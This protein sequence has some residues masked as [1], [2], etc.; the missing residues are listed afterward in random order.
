[1]AE[2]R[3][4]PKNKPISDADWV[5]V[6]EDGS[7]F[8]ASGS[9]DQGKVVFSP[10]P[11]RTEGAAISAALQHVIGLAPARAAL[12]TAVI[13]LVDG[14]PC[15]ALG[16]VLRNT[17][18]LVAFLDLRGLALLLAGVAGFVTTRHVSVSHRSRPPKSGVCCFGTHG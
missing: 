4:I 3:K 11:F 13:L 14:G 16:F 10:P 5:V 9:V 12:L 1:M 6:E 2:V 15:P 8:I 17:A 18:L 7:V